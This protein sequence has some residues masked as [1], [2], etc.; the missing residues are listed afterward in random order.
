MAL[1]TSK[2]ALR[3]EITAKINQLSMEERARQSDVV[4]KAILSHKA[5]K[6]AKHI[7]VYLSL[8]KEVSTKRIV[9][10]ILAGT[11]LYSTSFTRFYDGWLR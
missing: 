1:S 4:Q 2:S 3:K 9:E 7:S 10:A 8:S 11:I 6:E 5:F